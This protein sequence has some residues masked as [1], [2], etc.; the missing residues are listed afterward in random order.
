MYSVLHEKLG[1]SVNALSKG[2]ST[3]LKDLLKFMTTETANLL[4]A[5]AARQQNLIFD[6]TLAAIL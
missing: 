5:R 3:L 1:N 2:L 4:T 6:I